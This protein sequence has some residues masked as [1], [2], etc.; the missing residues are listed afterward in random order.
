MY[1]KRFSEWQQRYCVG[2]CLC[3]RWAVLKGA[4]SMSSTEN[5]QNK[6]EAFFAKISPGIEKIASNKFLMGLSEGMMGTLPVLVVGSFALLLAVVPLGP[7]TDFFASSG[8]SSVFLLAYNFTVGLLSIY[9]TVLI[10]RS[11]TTKYLP[12]DDG[13]TAGII[14]FMCF[15]FITPMGADADGASVVA[16][17]WLGSSGAFSAIIVAA[18]CSL[19]YVQCK[20]RGITI[21][22]P[23]GVPPMTSMVF[24]GFIPFVLAGVLFMAVNYIFG[25]TSIGCMHQAVYTLLQIPMTNLGGNIGTVL[26]VVFL[27]QL[28]W[29]FG[30]HGQNVLNPFV[31]SVWL[32]M[33]VANLEAYSAGEAL[34]NIV[35]NSFVNIFYFGGC[36]IALCLILLF[37]CKSE[38]MKA[39]GKLGIGPAIFGIGEPLNFGMPL[40]LNFK[41]IVPFLL[42][43]VIGLG[44]AY[45]AIAL[46]LCPRLN[47]VSY[48]FGLPF[49]VMAFMEGGIAPL[50]LCVVTNIVIPFFMWLPWVKMV[51][52]EAYAQEQEALAAK[53]EA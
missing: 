7:V 4:H 32:A 53:T 24:E 42:N 21:K 40:V 29:F 17:D 41:F 19:I 37:L 44:V 31:Q 14:A 50:I 5:M 2:K 28:L 35:G 47:G 8:L 25:L 52:K 34:P 30:I 16:M 18:V 22:M 27:M 48:I 45:L 20:K 9:M 36:Q 26:V 23:A 33:D 39:F 1:R 15:M 6:M 13:I 12:G 11:L 46:G 43:G 49:G 3:K 51:D 10:A 38:Q